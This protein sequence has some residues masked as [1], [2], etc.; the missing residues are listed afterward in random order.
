[1]IT[2]DFD[3]E[4]TGVDIEDFVL[5]RDAGSGAVNVSL[6]GLPV[7]AVSETRYTLDLNLK[8]GS[9]GDYTLFLVD[10]DPVT[11]VL[12]GAGNQS[13]V[14]SVNWTT[15]ITA[16]TASFSAV[17]SPRNLSAGVVTI[18]FSE[19]V[20][21]FDIA[22]MT[23]TRDA[24]P[25][26]LIGLNL[27]PTSNSEYTLDLAANSTDASEGNYELT[28]GAA[29][30]GI[31]DDAGNRLPND[32]SV[33]WV[34]DTTAPEADI[35][36]VTPDPRTT[37]A[38]IINVIFNEPVDK[39]TVDIADFGLTF[40]PDNIAPFTP[41]DMVA[42]GVSVQAEGTSAFLERYTIDLRAITDTDGFYSLV[43]S[44]A[45]SGIVDEAGN[46]LGSNATDDWQKT[47]SDTNPPEA[48]II[49]VDPD[50][51]INA[52]DFASVNFNEDVTGVDISDFT[53]T[54]DLVSVDISTLST[55]EITPRRYAIDLSSVTGI[56]G[57]YALTLS[58]AGSNILAAVGNELAVSATDLWVKG[59]T[60]P[61]A[62]IVDVTPDPRITPVG[63]VAINF[64]DPASGLSSD[65][66]GLDV[67]DFELRRDGLLL[68]LGVASVTALNGSQYEIDLSS[69]TSADGTYE[70]RLE[71]DGSGIETVVGNSP[72]VVDAVESWVT[73]TTI[74]VNSELDLVDATALGDGVVD[75][76]LASPGKQITLRAAIQEANN[77]PGPDVI[78]LP[79][80]SYV[81][82]LAGSGED[83]SSS[84][85]LD[86]RQD[87]TIVGEGSGVTT[88]DADGL[89]RVF[90]VF[91]GVT[92]QI[93]GVT[94]T[95]GTVIGS[96]DGGGIR[97]GGTLTL[98]DVVVTGNSAQDSGGGINSAGSL[99]LM[100]ST[101][102]LNTS[103]KD[104]GG[105]RSSG[106]LSVSN[107]T[108][109]GNQS[110]LD[111][112]GLVS[113]ST[114]DASLSNVTFSG[115]TALRDG[116]AIRN[117]ATMHLGNVTIAHN[118][119]ENTG[120]GVSSVG[121]TT[122]QNT[123]IA[124]NNATLNFPD[125]GGVFV[126][127]GNNLVGNNSGAD[128]SFPAGVPNANGDFVGSPLG[129]VDPFLDSTLMD[130]GGST[131]THLLLIGSPAIDGGNNAGLGSNV[132][133]EQRGASR[134]LDG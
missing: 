74:A 19:D 52:V 93:S 82:T 15:N 7:T 73:D 35:L 101:I 86:I 66:T 38:D 69:V 20:T 122:L 64:T 78:S 92:V 113:I 44:A 89:E 16:P 23:L 76:D 104:G 47:P 117:E 24:N 2:L 8:T 91:G 133:S 11:P 10:T 102:S 129:L 6:A 31:V 67:G 27:T 1:M 75:V 42:A 36:D 22:D 62:D 72:L 53:L 59:N 28:I 99:S 56:D 103:A 130:N 70:L 60:G 125:V 12:D 131:H 116:G 94:I 107:S 106:S 14:T 110:G 9:A 55:I 105:I 80:G 21:G 13:A 50:P 111:G 114:G 30:S 108:F 132:N 90:Q 81:L 126:T 17:A 98:D 57:S 43:L 85:D 100:N 25:V 48:D 95:G 119:A 112:G 128:V 45:G 97:S 34:I 61:L 65:V 5:Q 123:L 87:L 68:D 134:V 29:D 51:R 79:E 83:F 63:V 71:A 46:G 124:E 3:E 88:I 115:N 32:T 40:S 96:E 49:D 127:L 41:I 4:V 84:G 33:A 54:R 58:A 37:D 26:S 118:T 121:Q 109:S 120:G 77:L 18:Q 39:T